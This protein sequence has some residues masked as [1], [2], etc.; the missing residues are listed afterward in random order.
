MTLIIIIR[1]RERIKLKIDVEMKR[2]IISI[3]A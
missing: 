3:E 1:R 2:T